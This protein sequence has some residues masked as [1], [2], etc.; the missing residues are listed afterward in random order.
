MANYKEQT[1]SGQ[2]SQYT[3]CHNITIQNPR[4]DDPTSKNARFDE[5][6]I[7]TLPDGSEIIAQGEGIITEFDPTVVIE[8]VDADWESTG[9]TMTGAEVYMVLL[10]VYRHYALQRDGQA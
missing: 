2:M 5:E 4:G 8:L 9:E 1:I 7:K 6:I 3:R 10:S